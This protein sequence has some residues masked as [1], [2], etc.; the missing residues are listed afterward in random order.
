M[1]MGKV[2]PRV[3]QIVLIAV[4]EKY[5]LVGNIPDN[6]ITNMANNITNMAA[7]EV[8][9]TLDSAVQTAILSS[10]RKRR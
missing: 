8:A 10:S 5:N 9:A 7:S 6:N 1:W 4:I 3:S 2:V